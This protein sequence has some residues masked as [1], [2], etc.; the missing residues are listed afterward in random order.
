M[1]RQTAA[2]RRRNMVPSLE[3]QFKAYAQR[4]TA[5]ALEGRSHMSGTLAGT[6][7]KGGRPARPSRPLLVYSLSLNDRVLD[8]YQDVAL[9][10]EYAQSLMAQQSQETWCG[11]RP[12]RWW[13]NSGQ[14]VEIH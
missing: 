9:A 14:L 5:A 13:S 4:L 12:G 8:V 10:F 7:N 3:Q 6:P 2:R 1:A 11:S